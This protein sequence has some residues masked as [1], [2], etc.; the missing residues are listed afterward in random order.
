ML[1]IVFNADGE[2]RHVISDQCLTVEEVQEMYMEQLQEQDD[3]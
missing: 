2:E 1:W 3:A